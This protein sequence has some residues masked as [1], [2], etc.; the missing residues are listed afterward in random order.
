MDRPMWIAAYRVFFALLTVGTIIFLLIHNSRWVPGFDIANFFSFFTIQS[1]LFA[2]AVLLAGALGLGDRWRPG[3]ADLL[4]GAAVVYMA[5]TGVVY[6]LLLVGYTEQLDTNVVWA[7]T[8]VHR[9]MPIVL[10]ADWLIA[11]PRTRLTVRRALP[12]LWYPLLFVVYSL[13][14]GPLAGWYPYPFLDPGQAGGYAAVAAY[15]LGITLF[16]VLMTWATVT[17][18]T[19][20][21]RFRQAGPS[22]PGAPGDIE[23]MV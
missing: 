5:T 16:I 14:R 3:L 4:R 2:V 17:I 20:Q 10:V 18:G 9:V 8:V 11:P 1:N 22:R 7:D 12:W 15:C 21:R 13:L 23:Q 19:T 6:G